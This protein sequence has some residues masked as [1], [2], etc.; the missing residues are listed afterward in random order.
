[1]QGDLWVSQYSEKSASQ[2][3]VIYV[4]YLSDLC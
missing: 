1:M 2:I 3:Y 4:I